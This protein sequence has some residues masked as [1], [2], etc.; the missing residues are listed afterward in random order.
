MILEGLPTF[1]L[2]ILS[3][4]VLANDP[5]HAFYLTPEEKNL[6]VVR[7]ERQTGQTQ[8]AQQFHKKDAILGLKDWKIYA[9]CAGQFGADTMLYGYST[10]LPTILK[11]LGGNWS[12]AK[13]QALTI[14]CYCLGAITYLVVARISDRTQQRGLYSCIF[15]TVS[16]IGYGILI[17][18]SGL[19]VH[20]FGCFLVVS[21]PSHKFNKLRMLTHC[22]L[23]VFMWLLDYP[24]LGYHRTILDMGKGLLR[25][26]CNYQLAIARASWRHL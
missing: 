7:R 19:N 4:F 13:I 20:Y 2:G 9:F 23:W 8:S 12:T 25:R 6:T 24:S 26:V 3:F 11:A 1:V 22:R 10:F 17:S 16:V 21:L 14:P 18:D 15:G 5:E